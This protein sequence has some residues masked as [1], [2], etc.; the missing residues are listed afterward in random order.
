MFLRYAGIMI[1]VCAL[2][3]SCGHKP[4]TVQLA[5]EP[6]ATVAKDSDNPFEDRREP[7]Q[8]NGQSL[9]DCEEYT[10]PDMPADSLEKIKKRNKP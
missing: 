7:L 9:W 2:A 10:G 8:S 4:D 5:E 6:A 3:Q 1:F